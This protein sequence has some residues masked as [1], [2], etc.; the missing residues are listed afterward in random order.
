MKRAILIVVIVSLFPTLCLAQPEINGLFSLEKTAWSFPAAP[1]YTLG[2]YGGTIYLCE[3]SYCL[4][5]PNS[6]ILNLLVISIFSSD[7]GEGYSINGVAS[8]LMGIGIVKLCAAYQCASTMIR[9]TSNNFSPS[10]L[11]FDNG[12]LEDVKEI[13]DGILPLIEEEAE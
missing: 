2:F 4:P 8:S 9:K 1:G 12:Q 3:N 11:S 13:I 6:R 5:F 10:S 7:M